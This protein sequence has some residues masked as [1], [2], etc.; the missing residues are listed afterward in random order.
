MKFVFVVFLILFSGCG[1]KPVAHFAKRA[2]G[3]SIY[4]SLK[5]N[6]ANTESSVEIKDLLNKL[7]ATRFQKNLVEKQEADTIVNLEILNVT[8]TS[9]ATNTD[10]FTT[11]YRVN[12]RVKFEFTNQKKE[13]KL[14]YNSAYQDY[15]VSL[16]DPLITY[17]NKLEAIKEASN[18]CIDSFLTQIAYQGK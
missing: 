13:T 16:E 6:V 11:F 3:D 9:I 15:A 14:F 5:V 10:G 12:I 17:N 18:Q 2:L 1:Y 8:D 4:V 7:I